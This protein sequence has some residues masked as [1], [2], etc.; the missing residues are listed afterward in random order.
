[1]SRLRLILVWM[2]VG[3]W[4]AMTVRVATS[5]HADLTPIAFAITL[6]LIAIAHKVTRDYERR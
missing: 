5:P 2:T 1:M 3:A 4:I 6:A